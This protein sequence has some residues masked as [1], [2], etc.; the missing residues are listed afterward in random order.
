MADDKTHSGGC[1]CGAVRFQLRGCMRSVVACH[2]RQCRKSTGHYLAATAVRLEN[3]LIQK[4]DGLRWFQSSP[5]AA[6]GF[7]GMCGSSL[8]W[9]PAA[10]GYIAVAAGALDGKT[11]LR[12]VAH[13]FADNKGDYY[14][15]AEN[16][17]IPVH[18]G[19]GAGVKI[20]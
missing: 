5:A 20:P 19:G 3:L 7:C 8:F 9:R 11:G 1:L 18:A 16:T 2:C 4:D 15:F 12:L 14:D 13:I 17:G 6:R 10:G